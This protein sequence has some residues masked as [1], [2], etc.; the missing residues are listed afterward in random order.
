MANECFFKTSSIGLP[1]TDLFTEKQLSCSLSGCE[2]GQ[3]LCYFNSYCIDIDL[4]CD[5]I[6]HCLKGDDEIDCG[7]IT[8]FLSS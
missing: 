7:I 6:S 5:G 4:I 1:I 3:Y 8:Y 2:K